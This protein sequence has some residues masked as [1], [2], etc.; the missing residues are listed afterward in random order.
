VL[1][2]AVV[3]KTANRQGSSVHAWSDKAKGYKIQSI[4]SE[5][6]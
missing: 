5:R 6:F 4:V 2:A 1:A 3:Q